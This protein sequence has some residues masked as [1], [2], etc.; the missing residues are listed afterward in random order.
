MLDH[1]VT[2]AALLDRV[3][4]TCLPVLGDT[5]V[6]AEKDATGIGVPKTRRISR[7]Q[8][9]YFFIRRN[10][11]SFNG[12]AVRG[13]ARCAGTLS[14]YANLHGSARPNWRWEKRNKATAD[15]EAIMPKCIHRAVRALFPLYA[16]PVSTVPT[17]AEARALAALLAS[18]GK[19][20]IVY[21]A[22]VGFTVSEVAA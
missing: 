5:A 16:V 2:Q 4:L 17:Q 15:K 12:R 9:G 22:K 11:S 10:G 18:A 20:A 1:V 6:V 19:R 14:R 7:Q 8:C 3:R 13:I 21:P